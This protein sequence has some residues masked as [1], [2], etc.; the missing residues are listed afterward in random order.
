MGLKKQFSKTKPVCKVTF[1]LPK[2]AASSAKE[3]FLVGDFNSWDTKATPMKKMKDGT[4]SITLNLDKDHEYQ[5]RYL[6]DGSKWENDW[7]A[8]KYIQ[9]PL[10]NTDNSVV[11]I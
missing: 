4:F 8:D 2:E 9:A 6:I 3:V 11:V 5:Y 7:D 10:G 1:L